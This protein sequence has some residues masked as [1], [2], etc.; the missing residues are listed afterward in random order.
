MAQL[1]LVYKIRR[2]SD[3]K[4]SQ[5]GRNPG[6]A[7][8]GK[9]WKTEGDLLMHF[10]MILG[11]G[12]STSF[13]NPYEGCNVIAY[14]MVQNVI[15]TDSAE[16]WLETASK[17]IETRKKEVDESHRKFMEEIRRKKYEELKA[18]FEK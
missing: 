2:E 1:K 17:R 13:P 14:E 5:G 11:N 3:G 12:K 6:F 7:K 18:E 8:I 15:A 4:F 10:Y 16:S 9:T